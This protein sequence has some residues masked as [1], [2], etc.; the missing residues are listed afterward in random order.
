MLDDVIGVVKAWEEEKQPKPKPYKKEP[1]M[2][3]KAYCWFCKKD[4]DCECCDATCW[5]CGRPYAKDRCKE[6]GFDADGNKINKPADPTYC[7]GEGK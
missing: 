1:W 2:N 6:F 5:I 4:V 3:S 7:G